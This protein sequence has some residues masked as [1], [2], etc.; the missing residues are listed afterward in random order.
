MKPLVI[1]IVGPIGAGKGSVA[2]IFQ[3]EGFAHLSLSDLVREEVRRQGEEH[4]SR[5]DLQDVGDGLRA[6]FGS[7]VLAERAVQKAKEIGAEELVVS[8]IK[9]PAEIDYLRKHSR[10]VLLGVTA[11]KKIRFQRKRVSSRSDDRD[12]KTWEDFLK[13]D[14]R[15]QG[16]GQEAHGQKQ[17][18]CFQEADLV[19]NNNGSLA[20]LEQEVKKVLE[21]LP[22]KKTN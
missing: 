3:K 4:Y 9:N 15:D 14:R 21:Y 1:G 22:Q 17:S 2:A 6:K 8:S 13:A 18:A 5:K 7:Q 12:I 16:T 19:I 20:G 11:T 10:L